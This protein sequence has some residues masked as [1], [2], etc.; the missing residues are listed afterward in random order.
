M[1]KK[2]SPKAPDYAGA[3]E[4]TG[5]ASKEVTRDQTWANRPDQYNPWGT[6][7]WESSSVIDPSTGQPVTKWSQYE[8]LSPDAQRALDA[9]LKLQGDRSEFGGSMMNRVGQEMGQA[10]DWNKFGAFTSAGNQDTMRDPSM[11]NQ[12]A[13]DDMMAQAGRTLDPQFQQERE[14]MEIKLRNQGLRVGDQAYDAEIAALDARKTDAYSQAQRNARLAS[15]QEAGR[16]QGQEKTAMGYNQDTLYRQSDQANQLRQAAIK[17]EM[18]RR[19]MSLNEMNALI[20][21]QQ[22]QNPQFEQFKGATK[23]DAPDYLGAATAQGNFDT[24][25]KGDGGGGMMSGLSS[26]AQGGA[27]MYGAGMFSDRRLKR[28]IKRLGEFFGLNIYSFQYVWGE[29]GVG[30][31]SD[32][33]NQDAV[34]KHSSGYDIVDYSKLAFA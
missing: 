23:A 33:V 25:N 13:E 5:E 34:S 18:T 6:T 4:K 9:E 2:S 30:V 20:S 21:G 8:T 26:M 11:W 28:N 10:M 16:M 14:Q 3:A 31:M 27:A 1:G 12:Q 32:E 19:G 22:V 17:E 29:W 15:G 7:S 24:A